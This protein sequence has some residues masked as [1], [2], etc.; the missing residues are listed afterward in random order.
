[1]DKIGKLYLVGVPI[2]NDDDIT[3]RAVKVLQSVKIIAAEDTRKSQRLLQNWQIR[4]ERLVAHGLHNEHE[5]AKGL[6]SMILD[7]ASMAY[8]SDAGMP[9]ISDPGYLLAQ[10]A[11]KNDIE[12]VTLPAVTAATTAV[13]ASG[14]PCDRFTFQGFLP[15]KSGDRKKKLNL[16]KSYTETLVFYESPHRILEVLEDMISVLGNRKATLCRELTKIHEEILRS[17]LEGIKS[18]LTDRDKILGE[19]CLVVEGGEVEEASQESIDEAILGELKAGRHVKE[20]RDE[21][22]EKFSVHK[23]EIYQ[24]ALELK[25]EL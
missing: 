23:K 14:I 2:G 12:V 10:E 21:L 7:G 22:A 16:L 24:R 20:I 19:I 25:K 11:L 13:V 15:R 18:S 4:P 6:V 5:G 3:Y 1:M 8:I 9:G 17:D